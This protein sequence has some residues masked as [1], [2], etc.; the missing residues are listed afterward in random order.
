MESKRLFLQ[1]NI[2]E[3]NM[4]TIV[5]KQGDEHF[6]LEVNN[7]WIFRFAKSHEIKRHMATEVELLKALARKIICAIPKV[8]YYFPEEYCFGYKRIDGVQLSKELY[9][10]FS[11]DQEKEFVQ[12]FAQFLVELE[13]GISLADAACIAL[14][15]ADWPLKSQILVQ[16]LGN[17]E[18]DLNS[19]F[20]KFIKEYE[21]LEC[22]KS[23]T[24]VIHNDLHGGNIF[25][26][27]ISKKLS[28][29]I[30][31]TSAACDSVYHEFRYLH[32]IDMDLV[33]QAVNAYSQK[34]GQMLKLRDAYIYC[35]ATEFSRLV[36]AHE[37][38]NAMKIQAISQ[39]IYELA[40]VLI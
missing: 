14:A 6:V 33:A 4:Q 10:T 32:L 20:K 25:I 19:I 21:T 3:L 26:D 17:F 8:T 18:G 30:D 29:I 9:A 2:P 5:S 22:S 40:D 15:D 13:A 35:L 11:D 23:F 34:T 27:P 31:F 16:K 1:K 7:E 24:K 36:E 39:R 38:K 28:G 37:Q 12:D